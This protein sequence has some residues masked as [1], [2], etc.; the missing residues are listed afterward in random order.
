MILSD[1]REAGTAWVPGH[2]D[3]Q[4]G[5][6]IMAGSRNGFT[7]IELLVVIAIIAM[8]ARKL[9]PAVNSVRT[10]AK[11]M[12]C[13]SNLGQ[14]AVAFAY[15]AAMQEVGIRDRCVELITMAGK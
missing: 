2:N 3:N 14:Q 9:M 13:R 5:D 4:T 8:L 7:L 6:S 11:E 1:T 15:Y 10:S 12:K